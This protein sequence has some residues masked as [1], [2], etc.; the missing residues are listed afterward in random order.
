MGWNVLCGFFLLNNFGI[1]FSKWA[2]YK[3][4]SS[5]LADSVWDECLV[6][7]WTT[8]PLISKF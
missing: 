1:S 5:S 8:F 3:T 2:I 7:S 4:P 6:S